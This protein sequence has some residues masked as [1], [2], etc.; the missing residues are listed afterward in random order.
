MGYIKSRFRLNDSSIESF[1]IWP[2]QNQRSKWKSSKLAAIRAP[3]LQREH[4]DQIPNGP[5]DFALD[6]EDDVESAR[7]R[8]RWDKR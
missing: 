2:K 5:W 7:S 8:V 6:A 1:P 3:M 4:V